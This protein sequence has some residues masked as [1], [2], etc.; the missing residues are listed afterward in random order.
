MVTVTG[1]TEWTRPREPVLSAYSQLANIR[2]FLLGFESVYTLFNAYLMLVLSLSFYILPDC[3]M[4]LGRAMNRPWNTRRQ[5]RF[6]V[7]LITI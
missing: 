3:Q 1:A 7:A 2:E 4:P 5:K 6:T